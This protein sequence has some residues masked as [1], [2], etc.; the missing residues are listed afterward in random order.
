MRATWKGKII[1]ESDD[2]VV[3]DGRHYFPRSAVR[4]ELLSPSQKTTVCRS[5]GT[6]N[7]FTVTVDGQENADSAW[8][9]SSPKDE[10]VKDRIAFWNGVDVAHEGG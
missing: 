4:T 10:A 7:Y 1:A 5:K 8:T 3:V 9:Y 2:T 6:A